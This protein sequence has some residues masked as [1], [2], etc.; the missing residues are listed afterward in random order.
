MEETLA[1]LGELRRTVVVDVS[2]PINQREREALK[3]R[4]AADVIQERLPEASVLKGWNH[5]HAS[6]LTRPDVDGVAAS[7]LIAG[8]DARAKRSV[9]TLARDMGFHPVDVGPLRSA[10]D[11]EKLIG[12]MLFVR[13]GPIRVLSAE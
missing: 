7:V 11:L 8:D 10:R 3:G 12:V 13:L 6:Q 2:N 1:E 4:S 5:V 9:F